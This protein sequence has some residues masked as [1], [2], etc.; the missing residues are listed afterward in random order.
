MEETF[1]LLPVDPLECG[2]KR[3]AFDGIGEL[4]ER[5]GEL[6]SG[7]AFVTIW[8]WC[9]INARWLGLILGLAGVFHNVWW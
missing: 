5:N 7:D 6:V 8:A 1:R 9:M 3:K 4:V 2:L